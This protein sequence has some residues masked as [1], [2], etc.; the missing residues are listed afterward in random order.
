[1][2]NCRKLSQTYFAINNFNLLSACGT[3]CIAIT[4]LNNV[5]FFRNKMICHVQDM[6]SPLLHLAD[7]VRRC[8]HRG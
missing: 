3:L 5:H 4:S 8:A 1:M 6:F 7:E 2:K